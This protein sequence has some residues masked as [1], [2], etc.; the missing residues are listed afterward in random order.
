ML[1]NVKPIKR[2]HDKSICNIIKQV[3]RE[4]GAIG[5]G[6]GPSDSEVEAISQH[7][8]TINNS[9][10]FIATIDNKVVGGAGIASFQEN[11]CELKKLFL[12][13]ESR[14][15][16]IGKAL[17][18]QCLSYAKNAGYQYCYLDT[19]SNMKSAIKLYESFA[20]K[21]L[22][23]PLDNTIHGGCDVWMLKTL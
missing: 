23:Q 9:C 12:L 8:L 2:T 14:G 3:G 7:Y 21:R 17:T 10:Y 4:Y 20:F 19:L 5:E 22:N 15:L 6:F 11:I 18:A 13:P 1:Y 16:G